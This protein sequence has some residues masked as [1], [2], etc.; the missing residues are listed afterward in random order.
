MKRV[1]ACCVGAL[2]VIC[3]VAAFADKG[4]ESVTFETKKKVVFPH[5]AH[6]AKLKC[7]ECHHGMADGKQT[8]YAEGMEIGKC[9]S[10]HNPEKLAGKT[11]GKNKLDTLKGAGHGN[12][13][14]C[15]DAAENKELKKCTT[16]HPK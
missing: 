3:G 5:A 7:G 4:P 11:K 8:P 1:L 12:C 13:K 15:H 2:F 16:C 10:C 6:Q 9:A 14:E